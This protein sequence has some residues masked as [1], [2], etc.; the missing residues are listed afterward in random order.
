MEEDNARLR[1]LVTKLKSD[2]LVE[3]LRSQG[4][5]SQSSSIDNKLPGLGSVKLLSNGCSM[6]ATQQISSESSNLPTASEHPSRGPHQAT[7][8]HGPSS[9]IFDEELP[10][11][12]LKIGSMAV[13]DSNAKPLLLAE[14]A[15]QRMLTFLS[16]S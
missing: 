10:S 7:Q 11:K 14:A 8:F 6:A 15:K 4:T 13:G 2:L 9:V 1:K 16:P 5:N 3:Q 12:R